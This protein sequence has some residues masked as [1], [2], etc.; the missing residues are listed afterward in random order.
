MLVLNQLTVTRIVASPAALDAAIWPEDALALRT[1]A[2]EL[3]VLPEQPQTVLTDPYAIVISDG[4]Y[5]GGWV[6]EVEG[7]HFLAH[8][9]EWELPEGRP[10]FAQGAVAGIPLKLWFTDGR[11][12]FVLESAFAAEFMEYWR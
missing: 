4:S 5:S 2:D 1:A 9:C 8:S 12:L 11:I 3:I 6:G 10:S 7:L